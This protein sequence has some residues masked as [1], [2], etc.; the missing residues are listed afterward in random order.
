M[1]NT[2]FFFSRSYVMCRKV[3]TVLGTDMMMNFCAHD[4]NS[5][6]DSFSKK[7]I[8][9]SSVLFTYISYSNTSA[10]VFVCFCFLPNA[11]RTNLNGNVIWTDT[12]EFFFSTRD[13]FFLF[14]FFFYFREKEIFFT[15]SPCST[16]VIECTIEWRS[17]RNRD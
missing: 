9:F 13:C 12:Q 8:V 10:N 3:Y 16:I 14:F 11:M 2:F 15:C 1:K 4:I 7:K 5:V 6:V 17:D